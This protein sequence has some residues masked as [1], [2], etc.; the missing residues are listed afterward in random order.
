MVASEATPFA[1][2]GGLADVVGALPRALARLG[3]SVDVV[4][5]KYREITA[6]KRIAHL[7]VPLGDHSG[8]AEV[9]AHRD[10]SIQFL[11]VHQPAFFEREFLYGG[12]GGDYLDN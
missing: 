11:F 4:L 3:H 1:K 9:F 12:K 7:P 5:P 10:G 2:T 8:E 6:G